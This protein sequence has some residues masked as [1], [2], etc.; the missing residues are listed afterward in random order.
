[1]T[2]S[3]KRTTLQTMQVFIVVGLLV[4]AF[5]VFINF[6]TDAR[7]QM[8]TNNGGNWSSICPTNRLANMLV[9]NFAMQNPSW[10]NTPHTNHDKVN[11]HFIAMTGYTNHDKVKGLLTGFYIV[12]PALMI[13]CVSIKLF[14]NYITKFC[15]AHT[16]D[17]N[18]RSS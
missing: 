16:F 15:T 10:S 5:I 4:N 18:S 13:C 14:A 1:M 2:R 11:D 7:V 6:S 9:T 12:G 8:L 17:E 3:V